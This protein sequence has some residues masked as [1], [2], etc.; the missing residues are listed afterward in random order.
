MEDTEQ[1]RW[2]AARG[3]YW[4]LVLPSTLVPSCLSKPALPRMHQ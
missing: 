4:D 3:G 2:G 1:A